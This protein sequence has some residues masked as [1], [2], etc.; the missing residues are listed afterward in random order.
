[1]TDVNA[2]IENAEVTDRVL[3]QFESL[4]RL[5]ARPGTEAEGLSAAAR[6]QE[7]ALRYGLDAAS[8]ASKDDSKPK[9]QAGVE[10]DVKKS[11]RSKTFKTHVAW[12]V[13]LFDRVCRLNFC[14][15]FIVERG[16]EV[17]FN[18]V[19][20]PTHVKVALALYEYLESVIDRIT[21]EAILARRAAVKLS[22]GFGPG[23]GN[24]AGREWGDSF[25]LGMVQKVYERMQTEQTKAASEGYT[26]STDSDGTVNAAVNAMVVATRIDN[27]KADLARYFAEIE[28]A[29]IERVAESRRA[30]ELWWEN[31]KR[32]QAE[33]EA[34]EAA[35][36][37]TSL[38]VS[39]NLAVMQPAAPT[40]PAK[41]KTAAQLRAEKERMEAQQRRWERQRESQRKRDEAEARKRRNRSTIK[42]MDGYRAGSKA[43]D[44]VNLKPI[45]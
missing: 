25:R 17:F 8:F 41:P 5:M 4:L 3:R 19:G 13:Q 27:E 32:E 39:A 6:V 45:N 33:R 9:K 7:F 34:A 28:Q 31:Y 18:V 1:M 10:E 30:S 20:K 24:T 11:S 15:P 2:T 12:K 29:E 38:A 36:P 26:A 35:N 37:T 42:D 21:I 14:R 43:G 40:I 23:Q 44:G 22:Q 16:R